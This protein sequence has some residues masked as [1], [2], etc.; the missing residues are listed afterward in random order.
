MR[1]QST[2]D[3]LILDKKDT[4]WCQSIIDWLPSQYSCVVTRRTDDID[5]S[6][7][8]I[9]IGAPPDLAPVI[10]Q[11][12]RIQWVQSTWAGIDAIS[13]FASESLI[14]TA[15]KGVFGQSMTE[16]VFGW[17]L[18]LERGVLDHANAHS[19]YPAIGNSTYGK[20]LGIMGTG[21]IGSV[22]TPIAKQFGMRCRGLNTDGRDVEGFDRV[23]A[24]ADRLLFAEGV[25][26]LVNTLPKTPA[27]ARIIDQTLLAKL[28]ADAIIINVGRG[29]A[30]NGDAL[31]GAL[32]SGTLRYAVLD[33]FEQE[34]LPAE[35]PFWV[36]SNLF[37]TS[38]TA[39]VTPSEGIV[40]AFKENFTCFTQDKPL[41]HRVLPKRGY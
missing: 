15:L 25:D 26:Y 39:A 30:V 37:I 28:N 9:L 32:T 29:N 38:H 10:S 2:P 5:L 35:H 31:I 21:S 13:H 34:P 27:T 1:Q 33:V 3:I 12:P 16:Y 18:A 6:A 40:D 14:V 17:L 22:L 24:S 41:Q 20:T 11:C 7:V 8:S 19:W 36:Q 4:P 23:F